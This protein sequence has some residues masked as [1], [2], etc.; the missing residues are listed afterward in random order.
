[1]VKTML[2]CVVYA[3]ITAIAGASLAHAQIAVEG[4]TIK[5]RSAGIGELYSGSFAVKNGTAQTQEARLY[6]TDYYT[7]ASGE[8]VYGEPGTMARSNARWVRIG[9]A[10]IVVP[11]N[12]TIEVPYTVSVPAG[13]LLSGTYWSLIM[14]EAIPRGSPESAVQPSARRET[15]RAL[16]VT[17]R[18]R[19]AVQIVTDIEAAARRDVR[20]EA[21]QVFSA[22][23]D[24]TKALQLDLHNTGTLAFSPLFTVELYG[25]DGAHVKTVTARRPII[26]PGTS[27]RQQF[28][29]GRLPAGK[30]KA[31]VTVDAGGNAVFGAQY[32]FT[33]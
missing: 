18:F 3:V 28:D 2:T 29:L 20:F 22:T 4:A 9:P 21:P 8:S 12:Q 14:V 33:F 6:Q 11:P 5:Q 27:L 15:Q 19:T 32:A 24:S 31:V 30:Y 17:M 16:G 13:Q 26:Y 10:R 25:Q 23:K 7:S 1:M